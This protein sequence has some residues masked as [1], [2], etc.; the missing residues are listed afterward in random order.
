MRNNNVA[1]QLI[2]VAIC[3]LLVIIAGV[4][5]IVL[6]H[7]GSGADVPN[8]ESSYSDTSDLP[9]NPS[10]NPSNPSSDPSNS[11]SNPSSSNVSSNVSS[12]NSSQVTSNPL[13]QLPPGVV[14]TPTA[15]NRFEHAPGPN[16]AN[17]DVKRV[18]LT[19]DDG[20]SSSNTTK[21]LNILDAYNV[22]ATFFVIGTGNLSIAK[23]AYNRG[24]AIGLH[25]NKHEYG[26][27]YTSTDAYFADLELLGYKVKEQ[28]G[29]TPNIIRFPGGSS[30][31][32]SR[33]YC[34]GIM[35]TLSQEVENR[36]Y[37]YFDWNVD[38]TDASGNNIPAEQIVS[39]IKKYVYGQKD[40]CILMH[41]TAA[42]GTTVEA[43][44][45]IIEYCRSMGYEFCILNQYAK[46]FHHGINN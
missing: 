8:G 25:A 17:D 19:F 3:A 41:D 33:K 1:V 34:K 2:I 30:N 40:V 42:K 28:I 4:L 9:S 23:D 31:T 6:N 7:N 36:G 12:N 44:P 24:H 13:S 26:Q 39:N 16:S 27:I 43:L 22:K 35:T 21:I 20:P 11:S 46:E 18:Y 45:Q 10:S 14:I 38:S 32:V 37:F 29:F 5:W 15:D